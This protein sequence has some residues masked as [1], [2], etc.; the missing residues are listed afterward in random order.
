MRTKRKEAAKQ[1][2]KFFYTEWGHLTLSETARRMGVPNSTLR[3]RLKIG[4]V[5]LTPAP[6]AE[7]ITYNPAYCVCGLT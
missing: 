7:R 2:R 6:Q 4:T 3:H 1:P 5:T